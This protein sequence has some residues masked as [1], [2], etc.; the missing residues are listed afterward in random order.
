VASG[1]KTGSQANP[2][3]VELPAGGKLALQTVEEVDMWDRT[4]A[5]YRGDYALSKTNDLILVGAILT[6]NLAMFRATQAINGMEPQLNNGV[7]TGQYVHKPV[8]ATDAAKYQRMILEAA[9]EIRELEKSLGIDKKTRDAGGGDSIAGYLGSLKIAGRQLGVHIT[10]RTKAY[11]EF[12]M[13]MR[14]RIRVLRHGDDEDRLHHGITEDSIIGFAE[15][16]LAEL[17]QIDKDF[18]NQKG[19]MFVGKL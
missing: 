6:Q 2:L 13:E 4:A 11:E 5:K 14:W 9:K 15:T 16:R 1:N 19:K 7:P 12:A 3:E 8:K 18:A 10:K 17:E